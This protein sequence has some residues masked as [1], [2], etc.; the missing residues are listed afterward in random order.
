MLVLVKCYDIKMVLLPFYLFIMPEATNQQKKCLNNFSFS[1]HF[2]EMGG[3][4]SDPVPRN[5]D[6]GFVAV[7]LRS[8]DKVTNFLPWVKQGNFIRWCYKSVTRS[9]ITRSRV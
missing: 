1:G 6:S 4:F 9:V 5:P 8:Y 7:V 3:S 2:L